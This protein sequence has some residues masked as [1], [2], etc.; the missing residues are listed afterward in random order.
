[1]RF[2]NDERSI[3]LY[4]EFLT[5]HERCNFQQS[6]Q[7]ARV[8]SCWKHEI[9]L[10]EDAQGNITGGLSV[11]IRRIPFFGNLMYSARG[12]ICAT[13]D[14]DALR[15]LME[16][17]ELLSWKYNAF[18]LRMEPDVSED[19][20]AFRAIMMDLGCKIRGG[21]LTAG[22]VIQPHRVFRLDIK[23]KAEDELMASFSQKARYNIRLAQ[24]KGI[25]IRRGTRE[26]LKLF[27]ALMRQTGDRDRFLTRPLS[28]FEAVW[29]ELGPEHTELLLAWYEGEPIAGAMPVFYGNKT[30]YAF[31]ASSNA[32]RN[33]MSN[34]LLQWEMMRSSLARGDA[35][36]DL[37][38]VL[39]STDRTSG[40][41]LFKSRFGGALTEFI[42]EVYVPYK[43]VIYRLYRRAEKLYISMRKNVIFRCRRPEAEHEPEAY[44]LKHTGPSLHRGKPIDFMI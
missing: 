39:E 10:A 27:H 18:G 20:L 40:L 43:P 29:D 32:Y 19:D 7:W 22:D 2:A 25:E 34:Y 6:V 37:R 4:T 14:A 8:K 15:Q 28:Y 9:I 26:D 23:G 31:G 44:A 36:Y 12:P 5:R 3:R 33:L 1:M 38:G 41:Y 11:L 35:V 30:W 24:R 13:D 21:A 17:A 16:G 42:G